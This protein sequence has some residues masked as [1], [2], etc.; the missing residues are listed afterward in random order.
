MVSSVIPPQ[1]LSVSFFPLVSTLFCLP[2]SPQLL[3]IVTE[4]GCGTV[5]R[6][7]NGPSSPASQPGDPLTSLLERP[8]WF[9]KWHLRGPRC[10]PS[11]NACGLSSVMP[12]G[13]SPGL[14]FAELRATLPDLPPPLST[15]GLSLSSELFS[16]HI[17]LTPPQL[18]GGWSPAAR[19]YSLSCWQ[20]AF[21]S[22]LCLQL[23][24]PGVSQQ[25]E[26]ENGVL[27]L[28]SVIP[29]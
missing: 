2:L 7:G 1:R 3:L 13:G 9:P 18:P 15:P 19:I 11:A 10:S 14:A 22:Q 29:L 27:G 20:P 8:V 25:S 21:K 26:M 24:A 28:P 12:S 17:R 6:T 16:H 5:S 4:R 23:K